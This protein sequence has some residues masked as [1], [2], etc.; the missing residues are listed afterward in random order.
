MPTA[1]VAVATWVG[2]AVL[3]TATAIAIGATATAIIGAVLVIGTVALA[4][5]AMTRQADLNNI[6]AGASIKAALVTKSGASVAIP[7]VYGTRRVAGQRVFL[8]SNGTKNEMLHIVESICEGPIEGIQTVWFNDELA[9]TSSDNGATFTWESKYDGVVQFIFKDGSQTAA[10][11]S[12]TLTLNGDTVSIH[13]DWAGTTAIGTNTAYVYMVF[14]FDEEVFKSGLPAITMIVKGKLVPVIGQAYNSASAYSAEP[15]RVLYDM[16]V[17]PNYGKGISH[18]LIDAATFQAA[19]TY[20]NTL[21][22][23]TA[24]DSTQVKRYETHAF[25]DTGAPLL[26]IVG[27]LLTT[28]R[29]GITTS[30]KYQLI[31]DKP[32]TSTTVHINDDRIIGAITYLQASKKTLMNGIRAKFPDSDSEYNF[33]ENISII[34]S[35]TLQGAAKDGVKLQQDIELPYTTDIAT[36]ERISVEEIN[37]SRQSGILEVM[38]DPSNIDL[39]VGDVVEFSNSVLGQSQ[40]L[41]RITKTVLKANH[42]LELN[43]REYDD[44]VYWDNNHDI[45]LN[46]HDDT[47]H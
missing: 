5:R 24:S 38:I 35:A 9:G 42:T 4:T 14:K 32:R 43:M 41:Y 44:N 12:E 20:N 26:D 8:G 19:D 28:F 13:P 23:A 46:N 6:A 22:D 25:V 39:T 47:E 27:Q 21:V 29:A 15:A 3:G 16:M 36:V 31:Q 30:D 40:K 37:Q 1:V 17:N 10:L 18:T 7:I 33:Q 34:D 2:T 11:N 45:I